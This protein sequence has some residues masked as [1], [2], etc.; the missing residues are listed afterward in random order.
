MGFL[1]QTHAIFELSL[2]SKA[3]MSFEHFWDK[4]KAKTM[5]HRE[6]V[7]AEREQEGKL[8][9]T[10]VNWLFPG[11]FPRNIFPVYAKLFKRCWF[12]RKNTVTSQTTLFC[13][14]YVLVLLF[15][16]LLFC[17]HE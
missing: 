4:G 5:S 11:V 15:Q 3:K 8:G 9:G 1:H 2:Q 16:S 17:E 7:S 12:L 13:S 6:D 10:K 14:A